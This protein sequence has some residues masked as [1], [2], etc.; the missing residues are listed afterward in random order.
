VAFGGQRSA[1]V[2]AVVLYRLLSFWILLPIGWGLWALI[3]R[4]G[5][6]GGSTDLQVAGAG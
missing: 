2:A 1:T 5:R 6:R 3:A 4:R